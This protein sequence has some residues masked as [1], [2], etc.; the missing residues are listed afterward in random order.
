MINNL[1]KKVLDYGGSVQHLS[2]PFDRVDGGVCN[3]SIYVGKNNEVKV[4]LRHV[5]YSFWHNEFDQKFP[6]LWGPLSYTHPEDDLT[7]LTTNYLCDLDPITLKIENFNKINT[8][9]LDTKPLWAFVGLEDARLVR[10]DDKFYYC[11]VRR[12]TTTNG[13][14][15]I[16][17]SEIYNSEEISRKRIS[18]TDKNSYC[19]K[20]WMPIIDQPYH[21]VKWT[22]PTEVVKVDINNNTSETTHLVENNIDFK[23][24]IRGGSQVIPYGDYHIAIIHEVNLYVP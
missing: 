4:N 17:L 18:V 16:E 8:S 24:D 22:N 19:E 9:K 12:D 13:V 7:L 10:W 1:A 21:F 5:Q 15:R 2:I 6:S 11:G 20:N 14:G 3:P 23:R